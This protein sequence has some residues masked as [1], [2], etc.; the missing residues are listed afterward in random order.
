MLLLL[1]TQRIKYIDCRTDKYLMTCYKF[2]KVNGIIVVLKV[3]QSYGIM[4]EILKIF[5]CWDCNWIIHVMIRVKSQTK[6]NNSISQLQ[7]FDFKI[8]FLDQ[9]PVKYPK[10]QVQLH[11]FRLRRSDRQI[12]ALNYV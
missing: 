10:S 11:L 3:T 4:Q 5:V 2:L 7:S 6:L 8:I 12:L 9:E 1:L